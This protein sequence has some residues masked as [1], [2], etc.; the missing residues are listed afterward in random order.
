[1]RKWRVQLVVSALAGIGAGTIAYAHFY[2]SD[3]RAV[4]KV[5]HAALRAFEI[6]E[7]YSLGDMLDEEYRGEIGQTRDE[8][9]SMARVSY[10]R[11]FRR[12]IERIEN[13]ALRIEGDRAT[14]NCRVRLTGQVRFYMTARPIDEFRSAPGLSDDLSVEMIRRP[15][16]WKI[17]RIDTPVL[18]GKTPTDVFPERY[19]DGA[20]YRE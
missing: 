13:L 8:A 12:R 15:E 16:G 2:N 14:L 20:R 11:I 17:S 5:F 6:G 3:E 1:M 19:W 7:R 4:L 9:L 18:R 10:Y